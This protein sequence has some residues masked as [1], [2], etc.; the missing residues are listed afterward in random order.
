MFVDTF[1]YRPK[2]NRKCVGV[3][4]T[5]DKAQA[6]WRRPI[7]LPSRPHAAHAAQHWQRP[8]RPAAPAR[9]WGAEARANGFYSHL[10]APTTHLYTPPSWPPPP[11]ERTCARSSSRALRASPAL[12]PVLPGTRRRK[13]RRGPFGPEVDH[14]SCACAFGKEVMTGKSLRARGCPGRSAPAPVASQHGL[15]KPTCS[16]SGRNLRAH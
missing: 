8:S 5:A 16:P 11:V 10:H 4:D 12:R 3:N 7:G 15:S 2:I 9:T 6:A 14:S 13:R 1:I